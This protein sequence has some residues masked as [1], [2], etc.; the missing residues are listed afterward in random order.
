MFNNV[1]KSCP[2]SK[3]SKLFVICC[4]QNIVTS[5]SR[6]FTSYAIRNAIP[7]PTG[8]GPAVRGTWSGGPWDVVRRSVGRGPAVRGTSPLTVHTVVIGGKTT[9]NTQKKGPSAAPGSFVGNLIG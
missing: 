7:V 3:T 6:W 1:T 9:K 5:S 8:Y 2:F 4:L